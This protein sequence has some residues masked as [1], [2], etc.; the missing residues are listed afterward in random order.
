MVANSKELGRLINSLLNPQKPVGKIDVWIRD[1]TAG[2]RGAVGN[3][4]VLSNA[5]IT[6]T[7]PTTASCESYLQA[8]RLIKGSKGINDRTMA[9]RYLD[10]F[11]KRNGKWKI[12]YRT[13]VLDWIRIEKMN[14]IDFDNWRGNKGRK[15]KIIRGGR[16]TGNDPS[17]KFLE[18]ERAMEKGNLMS[19]K[20]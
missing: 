20:L 10:K 12:V 3:Q 11:E 2:I 17:F 9:G 5:I 14:E 15:A 13:L 7:S 19:G 6:F 4:H 16:G 8:R 18:H 1:L